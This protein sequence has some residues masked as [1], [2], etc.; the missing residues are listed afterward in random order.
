MNRVTLTTKGSKDYELLDS[1]NEQKLERYGA[2][3]LARPDPQAL[4]PKMMG[5]D[6]WGSAQGRFERN[7]TEG[8]WY[9]ND[10]PK[11]W[12]IEFGGLNF[13]IKPTSFKHTGLF[14][15]QLPNWEWVAAQKPK[16][17]LNLFGYTGGVSLAAAKAGAEVTHVDASKTAVAW[18]S[19]NA[20]LSGL[21]DKPIR[22]IV[23]DAMQFVKREIKRGNTYDGIIMDPPA[24]GHGPKD[25]L[26]KIEENFMEFV[27]MCSELLSDDA[28]FFLI[29]GYAAGYSSQA[30]AYN[31]DPLVKKFGGRIEH[32]DLT[33]EESLSGR[34][35][36]AGIFARWSK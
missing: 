28:K 12:P 3:L 34:L 2:V 23:E 21:G 30:F 31:L 36:P 5:E 35:L 1:G 32:G 25:E 11:E 27:A 7:G 19:D 9:A 15:E 22:W 24:F 33:I 16:K 8:I 13:I 14:P 26:W 29:N 6:K 20:K 18:A 10:L 17:V 4:W